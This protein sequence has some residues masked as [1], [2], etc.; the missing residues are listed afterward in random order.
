MDTDWTKDLAPDE[1]QAALDAL[2]A[3]KA[4]ITAKGKA[5]P[6]LLM[7]ASISSFGTPNLSDQ[8][9]SSCSAWMSIRAGSGHHLCCVI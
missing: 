5:G 7:A 2:E 4:P 1:A 8:Y 6:T 9:R 3:N